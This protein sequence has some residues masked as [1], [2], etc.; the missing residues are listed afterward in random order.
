MNEPPI[1][2][3]G[4]YPMGLTLYETT[5]VGS[6]VFTLKGHDPEGSSVKYGIQLTDKFVVDQK[7]GVMS[8]AKPLDREVS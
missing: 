1:F 8:L 2:E 4:G 5:P 3:A 7:S 6:K